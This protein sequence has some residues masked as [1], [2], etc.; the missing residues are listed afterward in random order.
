VLEHDPALPGR[1]LELFRRKCVAKQLDPDELMGRVAARE[2]V[3]ER[4]WYGR[5]QDQVRELPEFDGVWRRLLRG[6]RQAGY[7]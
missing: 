5:L 4:L 3:W 7:S 6:L 2:S 1:A